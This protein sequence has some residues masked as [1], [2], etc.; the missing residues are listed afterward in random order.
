M[1]VIV[2][3]ESSQL[4]LS[5]KSFIKVSDKYHTFRKCLKYVGKTYSG[6][7]Y[8]QSI[9]Q[10]RGKSTKNLWIEVAKLDN[11]LQFST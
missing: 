4:V 10:G 2:Q 3:Y 8:L 11:P 9:Q 6:I 5:W 7:K 1:A